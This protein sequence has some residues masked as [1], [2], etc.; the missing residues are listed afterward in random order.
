M[1]NNSKIRDID[2]MNNTNVCHV[3]IPVSHVAVPNPKLYNLY[4]VC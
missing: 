3:N 2:T 4:R 1:K